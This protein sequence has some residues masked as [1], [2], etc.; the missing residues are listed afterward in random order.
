MLLTP[1]HDRALNWSQYVTDTIF[2]YRSRIFWDKHLKQFA[3]ESRRRHV[4]PWVF[5]N[6]VLIGGINIPCSI[7]FL[8]QSLANPKTVTAMSVLMVIFQLTVSV[9]AVAAAVAYCRWGHN[10]ADF[11]NLIIRL[12]ISL[13]RKYT[14]NPQRMQRRGKL[15]FLTILYLHSGELDRLGIFANF[16]VP[17]FTI[18]PPILPWIMMGL[19]LDSIFLP[20]RQVLR[21]VSIFWKIVFHTCRVLT[22]VWV[23][24]E[25][26][27]CLRI[28]ALYG[29]LLVRGLHS[30]IRP[31]ISQPISNDT[32]KELRKLM[33][34]FARVR[35]AA[36]FM[37]TLILADIYVQV[38]ISATSLIAYLH[39]I[40]WHFYMFVVLINVTSIAFIVI[41]LYMVVS[42]DTDSSELCRRWMRSG[43]QLT[44]QRN[45]LFRVLK[46]I[47][48]IRISYG[49][50]GNF[51]KTTRTDFFQSLGMN[52]LNSTLA[53]RGSSK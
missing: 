46:S 47:K 34:I 51:K 8:A 40:P 19:E 5:S 38:L 4:W 45:L 18:V 7:V 26:C 10:L 21:E 22:Y 43:S 6:F 31:L 16:L 41:F 52:S 49:T 32:L 25:I 36:A 1:L 3:I 11:F 23:V 2:R 44:S 29:L 13:R 14:N 12:E 30:C 48:P 53:I 27:H 9:V 15:N 28:G 24:T 17:A 50:L 35:D 20:F 42:V 39:V 37:F 33:L